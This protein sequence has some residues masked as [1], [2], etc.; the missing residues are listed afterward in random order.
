MAVHWQEKLRLVQESAPQDFGS[1]S[2]KVGYHWLG[3]KAEAEQ[4][5]T[6]IRGSRYSFFLSHPLDSQWR[7]DLRC[8]LTL[9]T[10]FINPKLYQRE[11]GHCGRAAAPRRTAPLLAG[12]E[13]RI[14][15]GMIHTVIVIPYI[16]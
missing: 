14:W 7:W 8:G 6:V 12:Q 16:V 15:P 5:D 3:C 9:A 1:T 10:N 13:N 11:K 4:G 2:Q